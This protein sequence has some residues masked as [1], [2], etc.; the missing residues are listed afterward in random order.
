MAAYIQPGR[1][2][3]YSPIRARSGTTSRA[4]RALPLYRPDR[5]GHGRTADV[6]GAV[7]PCTGHGV[8]ADKVELCNKMVIDFLTEPHQEADR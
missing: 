3:T 6:E 4:R 7:V 8:P 1:H 5:R 2:N